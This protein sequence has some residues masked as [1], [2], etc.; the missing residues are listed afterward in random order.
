MGEVTKFA[1][2]GV[3]ALALVSVSTA[4][5]Q[6]ASAEARSSGV[7]E[8]IV[9]AQ[10]RE[11]RLQDVPVAVTAI[12]EDTLQVNR[13]QNVRDLTGLAPGL[14]ARENAGSR[15][16]PNFSMRGVVA[17]ASIPGAD[18]QISQYLDGVYIG[19]TTGAIFDLPDIQQIEVLRGPQGTLFGRN[20]TA[21]AISIVTRDPSGELGIRQEITLGNY[22]QFR[23]RT[24]IDT[25]AFGPFSAYVTYV[26]DERRGDTRNLGAGTVFDRTNP[27]N[28]LGAT[29]SP[30]Y[31]RGKNVEN[32]FAA[33]RLAPEGSS[34]AMTY[35]FDRSS[36]TNTPEVRTTTAINPRDTVG[37]MLIGVLAA[38]PAGG[39]AF[40]PVTLNPGNKRPDSYN[41]AWNQEG[42]VKNNG[43][44]LT[45]QFQVDDRLSLKNITA[46][47]EGKAYGPTTIAGL[48]G[49]E[50]NQASLPAYARFAAIS[51]LGAAFFMLTPQQ[52]AG[53]IAAF[54]AGLAPRVGAYLAGYEANTFGKTWQFSSEL[55]ANHVSDRLNITAGAIYYK[56]FES[57]GGPEGFAP[58]IGFQPVNVYVPLG[59]L[60][61]SEARTESIA[62]Y[63]QAEFKITP[64]LELQLGGRITHDKKTGSLE[65]GGTFTGSRTDGVITGTRTYPWEFKKTKPT[66][67]VGLNYKPTNDILVYGKYS[68][69]FLSGGAV[70]PLAFAPETVGA[71]EAGI[72]SDWFDR[73]L[74]ANLALFRSKYKHSQSSQAGVSVGLPD[75]STVIIDNGTLDTKGFEVEVTAAPAE[76]LTISGGLGYVDAKLLDPNPIATGGQPYL[77]GGVPKVVGN[78]NVQY[79]TPPLF[80]DATMLFRLDGNFQGK[81]RAIS[82]PQIE[83]FIPEFAPYEFNPGRWIANGRIALRDVEVG[84]TAVE[85]GAWARNLFNNRDPVFPLMFGSILFSNSYQPARTFGV[86]LIVQ[87]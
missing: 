21:G 79:V 83:T 66:Y 26:H 54:E 63:M 58:V 78:A 2:A 46:Y 65:S 22:D 31:L 1:R 44:N 73:R 4:H 40:G 50:L 52:Q 30:R 9:T 69:G 61:D 80:G 28:D 86:D 37:A 70:G 43:H 67:S 14:M 77:L 84:P 76:G 6:D 81:F 10:K 19:G 51:Q 13:V 82:N 24:T 16:A 38:Q 27:F 55:Q 49:L 5:A 87:Y 48:N 11:Q 12:G 8:I 25:P 57:Y 36:G 17:S 32:I 35:K 23:S 20:A 85:V 45:T 68:T 60:Q 72:K 34:L 56:A 75:L 71:W 53:T 64:Q 42:F 29:R 41:N 33:L 15:G 47:R 3:S 59:N 7:E 18:R 74:R 62:A 39:G